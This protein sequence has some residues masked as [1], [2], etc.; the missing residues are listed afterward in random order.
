MK[1][2]DT[3]VLFWGGVFSNFY[4]VGGSNART[5]EQQFML[6]KAAVFNDKEIYD[7]ILG[8]AN[9]MECK[10]LGRQI[11][12]WDEEKW[13]DAR[14]KCMMDALEWKWNECT[15]F[16]LELMDTGDRIIVEASPDDRIW[17]IGFDENNAMANSDMW[18]LNLLG[19]CLMELR[20]DKR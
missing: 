9:P 4:R 1:I 10:H 7:R 16:R 14:Y 5:S 13:A 6:N 19:K 2:T 17:G 11:K 3:H 20:E 12:N 18:G 15:I 8:A